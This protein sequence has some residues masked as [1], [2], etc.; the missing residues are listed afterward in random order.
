MK[1][2][3]YQHQATTGDLEQRY[4]KLQDPISLQFV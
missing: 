4:N 3:Y 1:E 2:T